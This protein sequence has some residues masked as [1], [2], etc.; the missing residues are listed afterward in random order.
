MEWSNLAFTD[1]SIFEINY[2]NQNIWYQNNTDL[3]ELYSTYFQK[4]EKVMIAGIISA[5]GKS[6]LKIWRVTN[7]DA[8]MDERVNASVYKEFL[9]EMEIGRAHV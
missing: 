6:S 7:K 9:I 3:E 1:E 2:R 5:R 4:N 8:R